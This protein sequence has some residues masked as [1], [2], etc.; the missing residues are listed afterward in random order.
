M[1]P[2][3]IIKDA[4]MAYA[5][6]KLMQSQPADS[7]FFVIMGFGHMGHGHGVPERIWQL[8]K[9]SR[10]QTY[11]VMARAGDQHISLNCEEDFDFSECL[12]DVYGKEQQPADLLF[13][14]EDFEYGDEEG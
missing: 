12:D 13:M 2:A 1:F 6:S 3:Q 5:V 14:F 10:E 9:E 7:T 8:E 4:S 11:M